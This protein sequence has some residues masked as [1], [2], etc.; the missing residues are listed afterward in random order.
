MPL[1]TAGAAAFAARGYHRGMSR[2]TR[3]ILSWLGTLAAVALLVFAFA[4]VPG[5][6]G[7][8]AELHWLLARDPVPPAHLRQAAFILLNAPREGPD[9]HVT[10]Y[11]GLLA[12]ADP[13]VAGAAL[14]LVVDRLVYGPDAAELMDLT[15]DPAVFDALCTRIQRDGLCPPAIDTYM[16]ETHGPD[17]RQR[18]ES[19]GAAR[20]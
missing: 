20:P 16:T 15:R 10:L 9:A 5:V 3:R 12:D 14:T 2:T 11:R 17:W 8:G 13:R 18:C 19:S 4:R 7:P 6:G 1:A